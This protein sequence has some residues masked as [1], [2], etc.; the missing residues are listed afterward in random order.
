M[1]RGQC[2]KAGPRLGHGMNMND[3]LEIIAGRN[4]L[5]RGKALLL[6]ALLSFGSYL[7]SSAA[8][9]AAVAAEQKPAPKE[10]TQ[11]IEQSVKQTVDTKTEKE[12]KFIKSLDLDKLR[13]KQLSM[14]KLPFEDFIMYRVPREKIADKDLEDLLQLSDMAIHHD[15]GMGYGCVKDEI[16]FREQIDSVSAKLGYKSPKDM[17]MK[18][19]LLWNCN[20]VRYLTT[21]SNFMLIPNEGRGEDINHDQRFDGINRSYL[22]KL[23]E[24]SQKLIKSNP[25]KWRQAAEKYAQFIDDS[26]FEELLAAA[27]CAENALKCVCRNQAALITAIFDVYHTENPNLNNVYCITERNKIHAWNIFIMKTG[28]RIY[29]ADADVTYANIATEFDKIKWD[30]KYSDFRLSPDEEAAYFW[31]TGNQHYRAAEILNALG[32]FDESNELL[33]NQLSKF[34][35]HS[36]KDGANYL[37]GNNYLKI[38][39][40]DSAWKYYAKISG[41]NIH[42]QSEAFNDSALHYESK[43][44][45]SEAS[46]M[47]VKILTRHS[48][49]KHYD[50]AYYHLG[51]CWRQVGYYNAAI[52]QFNYHR[53]LMPRHHEQATYGLIKAYMGC[54]QYESAMKECGHF[55]KTYPDNKLIDAVDELYRQCELLNL[56]KRIPE[57]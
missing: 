25:D 1:V 12:Y 3:F 31:W 49:S 2:T 11:T 38:G 27:N 32:H 33:L 43:G 56:Y 10:I 22:E 20:I 7:S 41:E 19:F 30:A 35:K 54:K 28:R 6:G 42:L 53:K 57:N 4:W 26:A 34:R 9:T 5:R 39:E 50:E 52:K 48:W 15:S 36:F 14:Q 23:D 37:T 44:K 47:W 51:E 45:F 16:K 18:E 24:N 55:R 46:L 17:S 40:I 13:K 8:A 21:Y 29:A